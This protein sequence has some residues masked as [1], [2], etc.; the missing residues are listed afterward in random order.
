MCADTMLRKT[1]EESGMKNIRSGGKNPGFS[2][3]MQYT[4][5][6]VDFA[7]TSLSSNYHLL[8]ELYSHSGF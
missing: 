8:R 6:S 1:G 5:I 2:K 4:C 3:C 7:K